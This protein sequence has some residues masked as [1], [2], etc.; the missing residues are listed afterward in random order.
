MALVL[1]RKRLETQFRVAEKQETQGFGL[2]AYNEGGGHIAKE[3]AWTARAG[4]DPNKW[5]LNVERFCLVSAAN[6]EQS[7]AYP[8]QILFRW[9]PLYRKAGW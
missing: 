4:F 3:K 8:R 9:A 7:R 2:A 6:C 5:F 1:Y